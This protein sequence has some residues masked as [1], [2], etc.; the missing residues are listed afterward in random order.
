MSKNSIPSL[1]I[2][3]NILCAFNKATK[4]PKSPHQKNVGYRL[5]KRI[6]ISG[7]PL[8]SHPPLHLDSVKSYRIYPKETKKKGS[9]VVSPYLTGAHIKLL[10]HEKDPL[11]EKSRIILSCFVACLTYRTPHELYALAIDVTVRSK[12]QLPGHCTTLCIH[13]SWF[14]EPSLPFEHGCTPLME[15]MLT[16]VTRHLL[17]S[18]DSRNIIY[19]GSRERL[20]NLQANTSTS[21]LESYL[22]SNNIQ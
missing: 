19:S 2:F 14:A 17:L 4:S 12:V 8:T 22:Y 5:L 1:K 6:F 16:W 18:F 11:I 13:V 9:S 20:R 3:Y 10:T 7:Y 15:E 21:Q